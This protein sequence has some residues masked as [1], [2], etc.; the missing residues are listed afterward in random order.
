MKRNLKPPPKIN[1][2]VELRVCKYVYRENTDDKHIRDRL[3]SRGK[4]V[5]LFQMSIIMD[6]THNC[7]DH[8]VSMAQSLEKGNTK[9]NVKGN[10]VS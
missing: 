6:A 5:V 7:K 4:D 8:W 3:P 1:K 10:K 2:P 9:L